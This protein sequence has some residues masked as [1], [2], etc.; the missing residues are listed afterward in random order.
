MR[1]RFLGADRGVRRRRCNCLLLAVDI[2][3]PLAALAL[4]LLV[5]CALLVLPWLRRVRPSLGNRRAFV[6][7]VCTVLLVT[8]IWFA[9][10]DEKREA[11]GTV[12]EA[13]VLSDPQDG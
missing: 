7:A 5:G 8:V 10:V 2:R 13:S 12:D 11:E 3:L 4:I 6:A 1:P 9:A